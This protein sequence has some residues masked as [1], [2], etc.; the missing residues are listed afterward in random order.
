MFQRMLLVIL[1]FAVVASSAHA[2]R[3]KYVW[4]YAYGTV[5][6]GESELEL[7]QTTK[8]SELNTWEFRAELEHGLTDNLDFAV[9][10]IFVQKE[11]ESLKWD[12]FQI[13]ARY[14]L[15]PPGTFLMDP[16]FYIEYNRK[17]DPTKQNKLEAKIVLSRNINRLN[18]SINPVYEFFF[19]PGD[20]V[21][22]AGLDVGVS[23]EFTYALSLGVESTS[24]VKY[25][26]GVAGPEKSYFGPT[27]SFAPGKMFYTIGFA[28]G[29]TD[30]SDDARVR[31]LMGIEL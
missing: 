27:L 8:V 5:P 28:K 12:A 10:Q 18:L 22:E 6:Q 25:I 31:F 24:R 17:V 29:M 16:L 19:A 1:V 9:Y 20:P 30:E 3:R 14:K 15:A 7:Y 21:H 26:N 13:R 4:T 11:G 2:D 23:W